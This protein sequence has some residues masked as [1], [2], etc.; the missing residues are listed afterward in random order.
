MEFIT[1]ILRQFVSTMR[2]DTSYGSTL[3]LLLLSFVL[4]LL[5]YVGINSIRPQACVQFICR[6]IGRISY[7]P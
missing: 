7:L 5:T 3:E 4:T 1:L 6:G 2:I